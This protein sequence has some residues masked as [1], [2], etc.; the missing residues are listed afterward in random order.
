MKSAAELLR[1]IA[2]RYDPKESPRYALGRM[3]ARLQGMANTRERI[4]GATDLQMIA[5]ALWT[6]YEEAERVFRKETT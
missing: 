4:S 5:I 3:C 6:L 2:T 1:E